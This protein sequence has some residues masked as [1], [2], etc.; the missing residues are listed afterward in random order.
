[1]QTME[2][3]LADLTLR[4]VITPAVA[5]SRTTHREQLQGLLERGDFTGHDALALPSNGLRLAAEV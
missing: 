1:M 5:F 3:S 2:Q 4:H